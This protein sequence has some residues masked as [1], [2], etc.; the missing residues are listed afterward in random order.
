MRYH[1]AT[2][3]R[4]GVATYFRTSVIKRY[5]I[6]LMFSRTPLHWAA[7]MGRT[8]TLNVLLNLGVDPAPADVQGH[9]PLDYA[10]Q[11]GHQG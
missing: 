6:V 10:R 2:I 11:S 5:D 4:S 3:A 9:T 1:N 7:A 8:E